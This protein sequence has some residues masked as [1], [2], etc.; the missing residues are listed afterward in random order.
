MLCMF[1]EADPER[2]SPDAAA[3]RVLD[4]G[5]VMEQ[6]RRPPCVRRGRRRAIPEPLAGGRQERRLRRRAIQVGSHAL[7]KADIAA[8]VW[9][10]GSTRAS[11][12]GCHVCP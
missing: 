8:A 7:F 11:G 5:V 1:R 9:Q 4:D 2:R 3:I 6:M 12:P 10:V